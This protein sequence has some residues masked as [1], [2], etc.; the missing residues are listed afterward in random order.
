MN[1]DQFWQIIQTAKRAAGDDDEQLELIEAALQPLELE[2]ILE[3]QRIFDR[4]HERSYRADL[5][6]AAHIINGG[7]TDDGFDYFRGWLIAQGREV[8]S[9]ALEQ[10]DSLDALFKGDTE[11]DFLG[12]LE[13]MLTVA[14]QLWLERTGLDEEDMDEAVGKSVI[15]LLEL[16]D[17]S[18]WT[19]EDGQ[20]DASKC[21]VV[22]PRLWARFG[23]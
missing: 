13:G 11:A 18:A 16:G 10:P 6:G 9:A 22:Y 12:E 3:F 7:A 8:F 23:G 2:D 5:W 20:A 1:E 21:K 15:K 4:L 14:E 17:F 19:G